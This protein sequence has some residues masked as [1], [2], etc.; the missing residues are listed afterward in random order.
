MN[1][2]LTTLDQRFSDP[3]AVGTGWD[4]TRQVLETAELG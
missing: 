2:P 1:M 4:E 3:G